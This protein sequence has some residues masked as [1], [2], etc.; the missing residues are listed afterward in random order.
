MISWLIGTFFQTL[1]VQDFSI[2]VLLQSL[3]SIYGIASDC[4]SLT[5]PTVSDKDKKIA[6]C[7]MAVAVIMT[8][9]IPK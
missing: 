5:I 8:A 1:L 2:A 4:W 7:T 3:S 6:Y 9:T